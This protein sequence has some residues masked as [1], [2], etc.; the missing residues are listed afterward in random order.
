MKKTQLFLL[1]FAG[2]NRYSFQFMA[3]FLKDFEVIALE[4]PG[5]GMRVNENLLK[6]FELAAQ[7]IY[8][9]ITNRLTSPKFV[10]YGHSMGAYLA[11]R[12]SNMLEK[13]DK[14]PAYLFVSGNSGPGNSDRKNRFLLENDDFLEEVKKLGG[15]SD[16]FIENKELLEFFVPI[17]K[18]DFEIAEKNEIEMESAIQAPLHA[19]MGSEEEKVEEISN[20]GRF[21]KSNFSYEILKGDHFFINNHPEKIAHIIKSHYDKT[22]VLRHQ[23]NT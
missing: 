19:M 18:A 23:F 5:R 1:H 15:I 22:V 2:G 16:E 7:D 17:L 10:I 14:S 20:W 11:L 3:P 6:D 13:I 12:V 21:T 9:Q 4:L 8:N